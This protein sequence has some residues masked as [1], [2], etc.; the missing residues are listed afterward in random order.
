MKAQAIIFPQPERVSLAEIDLPKMESDDVLVES[1]ITGISVG[2]ERWAF[3]G[4]R[5]EIQFPN[6]PGYMNVG[7]IVASGENARARGYEPGRRIHYSKSRLPDYLGNNSWMGT[8]LSHGLVRTTAPEGVYFSHSLVHDDCDFTEISLAALAAVALQ[9]IEM[10]RPAAGQLALVMG[11]GVIGQYAAQICRLKGLQVAVSDPVEARLDIARK[12]GADWALNSSGK[13]FAGHC[14]AIAPQG[15]DLIIDTSSI[16]AVVNQAFPLLKYRGK[17]VFQGWYPPPS[18]LDLN[19]AHVKM[20]SC[21]FP[22]G[23][24]ALHVETVMRWAKAGHL[25]TAP[26]ITHRVK[27]SEAESI[28]QMIADG[29]EAFLGVVFDW[30][31]EK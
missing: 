10:A 7:T 19:S 11:M 24:S 30:R 14:E 15:F 29:S 27:P 17:M 8:H 3:K 4:H 13:D 12:L 16:P 25:K 18:P 26:M 2:T 6:V 21:Y 20:P 23:Y 31:H 22:C 5:S 9:G 1:S 28:Y